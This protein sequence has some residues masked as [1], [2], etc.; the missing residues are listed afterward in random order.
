MK[1][2]N[3]RLLRLMVMIVPLSEDAFA[4]EEV[5][6][7]GLEELLN[8]KV[9]SVSKKAQSISD[10]A[11]AIFVITNEDI[12]RSGV[13]N[14]PDALR[15]APGLHVGRIDSSKWAV[16]S[17]GFNGR[18]SNKL[19]V[20]I[21]GRNIY[22]PAFS[23][24]YWENQ[25]VLMEDIDRI[26]VIRG[27]GAA[28]WGANA[29]NGVINIIT[30]H[31]DDTQG[32]LLIGGGGT[33]ER[34]FGGFRY[35]GALGRDTTGRIYV[36]GFNRDE[37]FDSSGARAQDNWDKIQSGFRVDSFWTEKDTV[38]LQGDIYYS[39]IHQNVRIPALN[40]PS[41]STSIN[42]TTGAYGGNL[43]GRLQ[44]TF[45]VTSNFILQ[46]YYG[47]Y[48]RNEI[49]IQE[50][51]KTGDIDFQ[52]QF[53]LNDWNDILLGLG[54][55]R[56]EADNTVG[57][58]SVLSFEPTDRGDDYFSAFVQDEMTLIDNVLW[59]T[60]GS[61]FEHNDYTG[62]EVQPTARLMWSPHQQHR[63][64][65]AVSR[66]VRIPSRIDSDMR[67]IGAYV[68]PRTERNPTPFPVAV[69]VTGSPDFEA[70]E[71][72]AYEIGYRVNFAQ[73][74]SLDVTAFYND[75]RKLRSF[76]AQDPVLNPDTGTINQ[77]LLIT[78]TSSGETYGFESAA[79]WQMLEWW[80]WDLNYSFIKTHLLTNDL[81]KEAI[82][83][84]QQVSL[85]TSL[86]PI[87]N[88][89]LDLWLRYTDRTSAF[90]LTDAAIIDHYVT[91]DVPVAW[92]PHKDLEFSI[93]GQNLLENNHLEYVSE[94]FSE[95][96]EIQRGVY[97]KFTWQFD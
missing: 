58:V 64:W 6:E 10:A 56:S 3:I 30:K 65:A 57:V 87:K 89:H 88:T 97:G 84:Q 12:R 45:S 23:G 72:L 70:E 20:L 42:D 74:V 62:F 22:T 29:V 52:Y 91:L 75:Y 37:L 80:R 28:L 44:H 19:L 78:N 17:R 33:E 26:E 1:L 27:A 21:D 51:R 43:V 32:G 85:R 14:I 81:Y 77:P 68:P 8:V 60:L 2:K 90:T 92:K 13:T 38:T 41:Y 82:A 5:F 4:D 18:F 96:T 95:A 31:S 9:T 54:Y 63:L 83:P 36:K 7:M 66:A 55:R 71:L 86:T 50:S 73:S 24:V 46:F 40:F 94:T 39:N 49:Y 16:S 76:T 53:A 15:L 79:V 67:L 69:T 35:G 61:K 25:D 48:E 59:L 47:H 34:G 11:A 93:V